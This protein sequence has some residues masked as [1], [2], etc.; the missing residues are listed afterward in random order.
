MMA[1]IYPSNI[2]MSQA[3]APVRSLRRRFL[4]A[5]ATVFSGT[6]AQQFIRFG[7]NLILTRLL[8]PEAFGLMAVVN[9][10]AFGTMM[11][12]DG[13]I[14]D[15]LINSERVSQPDYVNT[16]WTLQIMRGFLVM[17]L[18]LLA[19]LGVAWFAASGMAP[20]NSVYANPDF[21]WLIAIISLTNVCK[22]FHNPGQILAQREL[23]LT[24]AVLAQLIAQVA[25]LGLMIALA[26][27]YRSVYALAAGGVLSAA[28]VLLM[29]FLLF[30]RK[31][32]RL[33]F[34]RSAAWDVFNY[35]KWIFLSSTA[36]FM[37]NT[38]DRL[39]L[40]GI[41]S[42]AS[43]GRYSIAFFLVEAS[44]MVISRVMGGVAMPAISELARTKP[45]RLRA[46]YFRMRLPVDVISAVAAG[47]LFMVAPAL[48]EFLYDDRYRDA[49]TYLRILTPL[50]IMNRYSLIAPVLVAL[51][52]PRMMPL[53]SGITAICVFVAIPLGGHLGGELGAITGVMVAQFV[54]IPVLWVVQQRFG[55][56]SWWRELQILPLVAIGL[57]LGW[58]ALQVMI[59]LGM[60][61]A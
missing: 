4:T 44:R 5:A 16:V 34:E 26:W 31:G 10:I 18:M 13:G 46:T 24:R 12:T 8:V 37:A 39:L 9:A 2:E 36:T 19:A 7:G 3:T 40:G 23:K 54:R 20:E 57:A 32:L 11:L 61:A 43:M 38:G 55:C 1:W 28:L 56:L 30:E 49:G 58:V 53:M 60:A 47:G 42:A 25:G 45:D 21:P 29:S 6:L 27:E 14:R 33:C 52:R 17:A 35:A 59:L 15:K 51:N 50:L 22:G 48:I 41:L